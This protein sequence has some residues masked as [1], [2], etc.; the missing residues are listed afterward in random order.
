MKE[1]NI[2]TSPVTF[3]GISEY[4]MEREINRHGRATVTGY[5]ADEDEDKYLKLLTGDVWEKVEGISECGE[6]ETL[7]WGIVTD[8]MIAT[9]ND[10][11]R[12]TL[13]ITTGS[14]LSDRKEHLRSYQDGTMTYEQIFRDRVGDYGDSGIIFHSSLQDAAGELI[15][16]Y[17]ETD[18]EFLKRM[19]SRK[20][21]FLVPECRVK[22]MKVYY[23]L[24]KGEE[25]PFP[26]KGKYMVG[27][28]LE[29]YHEKKQRGLSGLS[30]SDCLEYIAICRES[31]KIG[32]YA[33]LHGRKFFVYK[34]VSSY[35]DGELLH[36]CYLRMEKGM[37][38]LPVSQE[39]M[40][41]SSL[42]AIVEKVKEDKVQVSVPGDENGKQDINIWYPYATVYSTADGTG[43][44]CMPEPGDMVRLTIPGMEE[45]QAFVVSSVHM[46]TESADRKEPNHKIWK[47]KYQKEVRFTPD[48]IVLTNNKGTRIELT[49]KEGIH[50]ISEHSV[51]LEAAE[52]LTISSQ[53]GSLMVAGTSSVSLQQKKTSIQ[54]KKGISFTGGELKVQ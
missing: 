2:R 21:G 36:S 18:W 54:L 17:G 12:L 32:D 46:D 51:V 35:A 8:F 27:K 29:E 44:Y 33:M 47:S 24:P 4:R 37:E 10:Q 3:L 41:G 15:L 45:G 39:K 28:N 52:D 13:E 48:S 1:Y 14:C 23:G 9:V 50:M 5:I 20:H 16:Q 7:F 6:A 34:I 30:E 19:A 31:R 43:W 53:S 42:T 40:A 25:F 26:E 11:K 38:V 49:D 22:G